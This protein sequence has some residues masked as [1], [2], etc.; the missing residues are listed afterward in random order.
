VYF[1]FLKQRMAKFVG[2]ILKL[3]TAVEQLLILEPIIPSPQ[4]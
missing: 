3:G 2:M 1:H 4:V